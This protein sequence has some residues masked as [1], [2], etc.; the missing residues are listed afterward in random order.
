MALQLPWRRSGMALVYIYLLGAVLVAMM[1][2][3]RGR[4]AWRWFLIALVITPIAAGI[5]VVVLPQRPLPPLP[6]SAGEILEPLTRSTLRIIR[7]PSRFDALRPY[8]IYVNDKEIGTV[9]QDSVIDFPVPSGQLLIEAY[10]DWA[11]SPPLT[12]EIAPFAR[13]DIEVMNMRGPIGSLWSIAFRPNH[14]LTLRHLPTV[15]T[16]LAAA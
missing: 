13:V 6:P 14:Y 1:A 8:V 12:V 5:L 10:C 3:I 7:P 16:G 9:A 11:G 2:S 4:R 15:E